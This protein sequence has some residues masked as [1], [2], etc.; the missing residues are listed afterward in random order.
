MSN[1][2]AE[3]SKAAVAEPAKPEEAW[4]QHWS[5]HRRLLEARKRLRGTK[6]WEQFETERA[7]EAFSIHTLARGVEEVLNA[8]GV[9]S[10]FAAT[11][12][13]KQGNT[14]IAEGVVVFTN[15]DTG[16]TLEV[17]TVGEGVDGD[18]KGMGKANSYA[19]KLG[20]VSALNLGIGINNEGSQQQ[21]DA[22]AGPSMSGS[23]QQTS[24]GPA[25]HP[26]GW[27]GNGAQRQGGN[28]EAPPVKMYALQQQG[29][30]ARAVLGRDLVQS[31]WVIVS[32][33]PTA[34][35]LDAWCEMNKSEFDQFY[36]DDPANGAKLAQLI[37]AQRET[38]VSKGR[39]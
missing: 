20:L 14:T 32:N 34:G 26:Q 24:Q 23:P 2:K 7:F 30:Q 17:A 29:V 10:H 9:I 33:S 28:G 4:N 12:W 21:A 1:K 39:V 18:D 22:K 13:Q 6:L 31:C 16:E 27:G 5:L 25:G 3:P 37:A 8:C 19:R 35:A 38:L 15:V 11:R 36:A